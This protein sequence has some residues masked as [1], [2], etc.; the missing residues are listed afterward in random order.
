MGSS[1]HDDES[2]ML[3]QIM[4][5]IPKLPPHPKIRYAVTL[6][7]G[8][9]SKWTRKHPQF[10]TYQMDFI[11]PGFGDSEL[12]AAAAKSLKYLCQDCGELL[13]GYIEQ[14]LPFYTNAMSTLHPDDVMDITEGIAHIIAK[15]DLEN[16]LPLLQS[17]TLPIIQ[18]LNEVSQISHQSMTSRIEKETKLYLNRLSVFMKV[19]RPE[20]SLATPHPVVTIVESFWPV[21]KALLQRFSTVDAITEGVAKVFRQL[22][23]TCSFH[24]LPHLSELIQVLVSQYDSTHLSCYLWVAFHIVGTFS[25][26]PNGFTMVEQLNHAMS[27]MVN[28]LS[29]STFAFFEKSGFSSKN[30][31]VLEEYFHFIRMYSTSFPDQFHSWAH[32]PILLSFCTTTFTEV[33]HPDALSSLIQFI[34]SYMSTLSD[35]SSDSSKTP[36]LQLVHNNAQTLISVII[37]ARLEERI[38]TDSLN[39]V[40]EILRTLGSLYGKENE[41]WIAAVV[42][43][44][45]DEIVGAQ[46][47]QKFLTNYIGGLSHKS[48]SST[49]DAIN[50]LAIIYR[51]KTSRSRKR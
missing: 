45:S 46:D 41:V 25:K 42:G 2:V 22:I 12:A 31:D 30:A 26:I 50:K 29:E 48:G 40:V 32:L 33:Y 16:M 21:L 20:V 4:E 38:P 14:L 37:Q 11:S 36:S 9:Y 7:I 49:R 15:S 3:P 28:Q 6:V 39:E 47:K 1:I 43:A 34:N 5:L 27:L 8:V 51:R 44:I 23:E 17:F 24:F 18:R 10:V 13:L 35:S 19:V